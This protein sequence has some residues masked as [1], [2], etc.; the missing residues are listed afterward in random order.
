MLRS[1]AGASVTSRPP[2]KI[3]PDVGLLRPA[4]S[5]SSVV[6][7]EPL[8]PRMVTNSPCA[9]SRSTSSAAATV[10][11]RLLTASRRMSLIASVAM[12]RSAAASVSSMIASSC[13]VDRNHLAF[14]LVRMPSSCSARW[15]A[16]ALSR[17][18]AAD[19]AIVAR[20]RTVGE[21]HLEDRG[22]AFDLDRL[23][24]LLGDRRQA[25]HQARA[26]ALEVA[27][28]G[29]VARFEHVE[30]GECRGHALDIA[31]VGAAMHHA[32]V[33]QGVHDV[34]TAADHGERKAGG[35]RLGVDREVGL[36][37]VASLRALQADAKA[38]DH[39]VADEE[40]A[41]AAAKIAHA[42]RDSPAWAASA[43]RSPSPAP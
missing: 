17:S 41:V 1:C 6:L 13:A 14:W 42:L 37:A 15:K 30:R 19:F 21:E 4:I 18:H 32:L 23:P 20:R 11:Y 28:D 10:P 29:A 25:L 9:T 16:S 24:V 31:V 40:R 35:D 26:A 27:V 7:P 2:M 5:D 34:A 12:A 38:G 3:R 39:L 8:G 33:E 43:R 36:H 22:Q